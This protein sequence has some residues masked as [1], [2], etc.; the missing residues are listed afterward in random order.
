[1]ALL[2]HASAVFTPTPAGVTD[3]TALV[4]TCPQAAMRRVT[5]TARKVRP[6]PAGGSGLLVPM[7]ATLLT[8]QRLTALTAAL[9]TK[10]ATPAA[11]VHPVERRVLAMARAGLANLEAGPK[12]RVDAAVG[13]ANLGSYALLGS[14]GFQL[15]DYTGALLPGGAWVGQHLRRGTGDPHLSHVPVPTPELP[16]QLAR[17]GQ[18]ATSGT[19]KAAV[20]A[21]SD[22]DAGGSRLE[23]PAVASAGRPSTPETPTP[24]GIRNRPSR[25]AVALEHHLR[26]GFLG[27]AT[28][29]TSLQNWLP[30]A[31][32][33]PDRPLGAVHRRHR[34]DLR[35]PVRAAPRLRR[36]R[37]RL[38]RGL[39][40][41]PDAPPQRLRRTAR[42][43]PVARLVRLALV[44]AADSDP[45]RS[46]GVADRGK[47]APARKGVLRG[48][49]AHRPRLLRDA[50]GVD[51]HR[52]DDPVPL[53]D[54]P[55][56]Q[57][58]RPHRGLRHLAAHG[59][60]TRRTGRRR[61]GHAPRTRTRAP[62]SGG[63]V[64]S[65]R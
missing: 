27:G 52:R 36:V 22:R 61:P 39:L 12:P 33:V 29:V 48:W 59:A 18:A 42:G 41:G 20:Q 37:G 43:R 47:V 40:A 15:P 49:R 31:S 38:R 7:G 6:A 62:A 58:R 5:V 44:G 11:T 14:L 16:L 25:G 17:P 57:V 8:H 3:P 45:R 1:M 19:T 4:T 24:T 50:D 30:A 26:Q 34:P 65:C 64:C 13:G 28:G 10:V 53:L 63:V 55:V 46:V 9:G 56:G 51:G 35:P 54:D 23:R 32:D 21:F 2:H 60:G